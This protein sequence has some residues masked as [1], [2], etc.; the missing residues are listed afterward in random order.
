MACSFFRGSRGEAEST[1]CCSRRPASWCR[2]T[3]SRS[4]GGAWAR[5]G[6]STSPTT[7]RRPSDPLEEPVAPLREGTEATIRLT[8][9]SGIANRYVALNPGPEDAKELPDGA[10]LTTDATT[11]VVDLDQ[12]FNTLDKR[13]RGGLRNVIRGFAEQYAGRGAEA[14]E[15]A[16]YF[17]PL[18][19]TLA[20]ARRPSSTEGRAGA[21]AA[22]WSTRRGS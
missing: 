6:R 13:T 19:S 7:T 9:L 18:L 20:Q 16:K 11:S 21:H 8:S 1:R 12:I 17:N 4:A 2:T 15:A 10:T 14:N 22:S 3:T 5:C